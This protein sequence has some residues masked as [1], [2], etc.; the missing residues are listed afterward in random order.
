MTLGCPTRDLSASLAA[1][2]ASDVSD[3]GASYSNFVNWFSQLTEEDF[4]YRFGASAHESEVLC[5]RSAALVP[6]SRALTASLRRP[7]GNV[8]CLVAGIQYENRATLLPSV[9]IGSAVSLIRDYTNQYD[10]SA[11]VVRV[12]GNT[13]G[14]I[15]RADGRLWAPRMD[16]GANSFGQVV[17]IDRSR[18]NPQVKIEVSVD[19]ALQ[20]SGS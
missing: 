6:S 20:G 5:R 16:A 17:G 10:P 3:G 15:P 4:G 18:S 11:I 12:D 14:Y 8:E 19:N 13:L 7:I 2:F 9:N 1:E